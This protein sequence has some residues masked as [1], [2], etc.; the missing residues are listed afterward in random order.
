MAQKE[1]IEEQEAQL[2]GEMEALE[3]LQASVE[4]K[5]DEVSAL[6]SRHFRPDQ[7]ACDADCGGSGGFLKEKIIRL[8]IRKRFLSS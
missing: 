8:R 7:P 1:A 3:E 6:A 2:Q 4:K 5:Q